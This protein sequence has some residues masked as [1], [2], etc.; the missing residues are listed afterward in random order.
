LD[1]ASLPAGV[2]R[3]KKHNPGGEEN[4][5]PSDASALETPPRRPDVPA[6][7]SGMRPGA[8][9]VT[10]NGTPF[11]REALLAAVRDSAKRPVRLSVEQDGRRYDVA[12]AYAG[13]LRY[14]RL[15]RLAD[16]PDTL[17]T[18]LAPR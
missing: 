7:R 4:R 12:I 17:T 6:F 8:R 3:A 9:I 2:A 14:P 10:V 15:E 5:R 11:G 1:Q 16:R 13:P 18:L